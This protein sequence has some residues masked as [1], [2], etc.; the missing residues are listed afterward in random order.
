MN[1]LFFL[2]IFTLLLSP[3]AAKDAQP[4]K[5]A[6]VNASLIITEAGHNSVRITLLPE[7]VSSVPV[8]PLLAE[9]REY[10]S[11]VISLSEIDTPVSVNAGNLTVEIAIDPLKIRVLNQN[12][13]LIQELMF[14]SEGNVA[15]LLDEGPVLGMGEGG[16]RLGRDWRE[17][18]IE[19]DRR[20]RY[21]EMVPRWQA[22]A[23][24]SRNPAAALTGTSG[25]GIYVAAPWVEVDL[26]DTEKGL[27]IPWQPPA[28][29]SDSI[30]GSVTRS[31]QGRPPIDEMVPGLFDI[32]VFD[33]SDPLIYMDEWAEVTGRAVIPPKWALGYMQSH[34]TL[35]DEEQMIEIVKT[36]RE[37]KI[38][39]EAVIYLGTGFCPRGWNTEQPSFD[40]NPEV[41]KRDPSE[42]IADLHSLNVKVVNHIVPWRRDKLP[43]IIGNIPPA[44]GET[45]DNSHMLH[46]WLQHEDLVKAGVDAWW[47]DEGD[48][49]NLYERINRHKLYYEGPLHTTPGV[50]PWSLHRNGHP[51]I[52]QWGG[53]VWSGDTDS[54]WKTLEGQIAVGVNY[55]L[56]LSPFWGSDIGGFYPNEELTGE[57]YARW[58]QFGAFC[59]S[60]RS[61]GRTW[62]T[63]LP[64]GWGLD[65][66]GPRENR[67]NPLPSE[68][69]N[70]AIE[71][72]CRDYTELRYR[73]MPYTYTLAWESRA[74]GMPMMR[75][76]WLHY[77][78]DKSA[79]GRGDQYLWGEK[80]MIAPV[81]K[82]GATSR[83]LW[84]PEG[85]W[86][87]WWTGEAVT[88]NREI[89]KDV[90]LSV[91]PIYL[92][93]G[94]IIPMDP[95]KQYTGEEVNKP[96][97]IRI[98]EGDNGKFT[99]YHDDGE[100]TSYLD[101]KYDLTL[102]SWDNEKRALT[103]EPA[104]E[105]TG[106]QSLTE[107]LIVELYPLQI[108]KEIKYKGKARSYRM[109]SK[110]K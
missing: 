50:R 95:V 99:L 42:V 58:Y 36:F 21:H 54:G 41:F 91:M 2:L 68:L 107:T 15:F 69:G 96:M 34:R 19:F 101:G 14:D 35:E 72:V 29:R 51:G 31:L 24:G 32:F 86:Y 87:D 49:F 10:P 67:N 3:A 59:P 16:P 23:Y 8:T 65:E 98:Y 109:P 1:R 4:V 27:F 25:W 83:K 94:A 44:T 57:L 84:L 22:N 45:V 100:T 12:G 92:K 77:P 5:S 63:R 79:V 6:G 66:M 37:K 40:F 64:W 110:K 13:R 81:Y 17:A 56:S 20:G 55:S 103:I 102:L 26:R 75:A 18:E 85:I 78:E 90:D 62:W 82:P 11:P 53:W 28:E 46:Y 48:W 105:G 33:A 73:M 47:P 88:G 108:V 7:T 70:E 93:A 71:P 97:T 80:M 30:D 60:F 76:M 52:A 89:T 38:P 39:V 106:E 74:T 9:G 104:Y 43:T 61:H